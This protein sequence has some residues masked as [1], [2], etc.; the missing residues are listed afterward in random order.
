VPSLALLLLG[1]LA[2]ERLLARP[3]RALAAAACVAVVAA[4]G[5]R[6]FAVAAD[7][8][9]DFAFNEALLEDDPGHRHALRRL[10]REHLDRGERRLAFAA[11]RPSDDP[12]GLATR[13]AGM[14]DLRRAARLLER[15]A[16]L[17][18]TREG[19]QTWKA[20]GDAQSALRLYAAAAPSY[21]EALARKRIR[22][23]GRPVAIPQS[24]AEVERV[25][26]RTA[27]AD[28]R[29]VADAY[30]RRAVA[31]EHTDERDAAIA[32]Y[33]A[34]TAWDPSRREYHLRAA[35]TLAQTGRLREAAAH[36]RLVRDAAVGDQ[37]A[38]DTVVLQDTVEQAALTARR[39]VE[40]GRAFAAAGRASDALS[41]YLAAVSAW[42][43][44]P[45]G[46]DAALGL[47][48]AWTGDPDDAVLAL[49]DLRERLADAGDVEALR[50]DRPST[51]ER[52]EALI[53]RHDRPR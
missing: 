29:F 26:G 35:G 24:L 33:R 12:T 22:V 47:L 19:A 17:R 7:W 13:D 15:A 28:R 34:A 1:G 31:L 49:E 8:R 50:V 46:W 9:D 43:D 23:D 27:P 5:A 36:Y 30:F 20:L 48:E 40:E 32:S 11:A 3:P 37:R 4:L 38:K 14:A 2:A 6:S 45:A 51:G 42:P 25:R 53:R 16:G 44:E 39:K 18:G 10:G 21:R 52:I 41:A